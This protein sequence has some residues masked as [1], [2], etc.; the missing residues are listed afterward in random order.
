MHIV[1]IDEMRELEA[2]NHA[3]QQEQ[4]KLEAG[5]KEMRGQM[6]QLTQPQINMPIPD[7]HPDEIT[8][9]ESSEILIPANRAVTL[10]LQP[11][12][13][14]TAPER[15]VALLDESARLGRELMENSPAPRP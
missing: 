11:G 15:N 9:G 8:R 6:A 3:I 14:T 10:A 5:V 13:E 4:A 1:T 7:L 12:H 2:R